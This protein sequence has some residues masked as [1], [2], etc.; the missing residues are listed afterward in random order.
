[1]KHLINSS[2]Y[3]PPTETNFPEQVEGIELLTGYNPIPESFFRSR[4]V[5]VHLPYAIDWYA[6]WSGNK[7]IPKEIP[8][9]SVKHIFYGRDKGDI[10]DNLHSAIK[11][12]STLDPKYGI[13]HAGNVS[14][15]EVLKLT[16]SDSD[17][18]ILSAF[19]E[20]V[21]SV[22]AL[23]PNTEPP[24]RILFENQWWPGLRM[25]DSTDYK[26][27]CNKI[28]FENWGLC[29]D[30]GHLL[31][32]T[33]GAQTEDQAIDI[34][35]NVVDKFSDDMLES[36]MTIHLHTNTCYNYL[37][38]YKPPHI[39]LTSITKLIELAYSHVCNMD[40]HEPFTTKR[41]AGLVQRLNPD[42]ITHEMGA[43]RYEKKINDC[44]S[45]ISILSKS[46]GIK[47]QVTFRT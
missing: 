24:F 37:K 6:A 22:I 10:I 21:N 27:L 36:I 30:T 16:Y 17:N 40:Q 13:L 23:F 12:A 41:V 47:E 43:P 19:T 25:L 35:E 3:D 14:I 5:S 44:L 15:S 45:Q 28:E 9:D 8:D 18:K 31:V 33:K 39:E 46:D 20:L 38:N 11:L 7:K 1:M 26:I 29:F 42:Y 32:A 34:L 4:V 2:I